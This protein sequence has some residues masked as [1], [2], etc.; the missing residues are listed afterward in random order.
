MGRSTD[1]IGVRRFLIALF[2]AMGIL[3]G[4]SAP[5]EAVKPAPT[6]DEAL[7]EYEAGFTPSDYDPEPGKKGSRFGPDTT[8]TTD[9]TAVESSTAASMEMVPGFRV[10]LVATASIDEANARKAEAEGSFP[11]ERIYIEYDPPTY[12]VRAGNFQNRIDADRFAKL[13]SSRGFQDAWPVP[14][15]VF[16]N[17]SPPPRPPGAAEEAE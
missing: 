15:R 14:E 12:K 17:P 1:K 8:G 16:K 10:Q 11:G 5:K 6:F 3:G 7:K 2:L 9:T 4:C 13:A